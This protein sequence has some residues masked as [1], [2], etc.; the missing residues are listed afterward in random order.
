MLAGRRM[1][2]VMGACGATLVVAVAVAQGAATVWDGVYTAEQAERGREIYA[3]TC[4]VCHGPALGGVESAPPLTGDQ[5]NANWSGT[6]IADLAERIRISMPV[7]KPGTLSR[8]Q[9]AAIVAFILKVDGFPSGTAEIDPQLVT[10][11][12]VKIISNK[13][14]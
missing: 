3:T 12:P 5:F 13:P 1:R 8:P 4:A 11:S 2:T 7:D 6:T 9:I 10:S 14:E